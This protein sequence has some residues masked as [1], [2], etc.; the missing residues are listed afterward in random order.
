MFPAQAPNAPRERPFR[1]GGPPKDSYL[2]PYPSTPLPMPFFYP[3][4]PSTSQH[5]QAAEVPASSF[6]PSQQTQAPDPPASSFSHAQ[7]NPSGHDQEAEAPAPRTTAT[8]PT[9]PSS[10]GRRHRPSAPNG[11]PMPSPFSRR[12][13]V[14]PQPE[15]P[16]GITLL[17]M[18][19]LYEAMGHPDP[20]NEGDEAGE[21]NRS[22]EEEE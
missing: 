13:P 2:D 16:G 5:I 18:H 11:A 20:S 21:Q 17:R 15:G 1:P 6:Y 19:A 7:P 8:S 4:Q 14:P 12:I 3:Q 9:H 22:P 10:S